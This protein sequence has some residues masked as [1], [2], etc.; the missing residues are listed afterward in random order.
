MVSI[1]RLTILWE[2][3][4]ALPRAQGRP[5]TPQCP[6]HYRSNNKNVTQYPS[7]LDFLFG[8][9]PEATRPPSRRIGGWCVELTRGKDMG[10]TRAKKTIIKLVYYNLKLIHGSSSALET[11]TITY[12]R[13]QRA[14]K[15]RCGRWGWWLWGEKHLR[16]T[17]TKGTVRGQ[18]R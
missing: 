9:R 10:H 14:K 1:Q 7:I 16:T 12:L 5:P 15:F 17:P 13:G 18:C 8:G 3:G 6:L 4:S 11:G 2:I